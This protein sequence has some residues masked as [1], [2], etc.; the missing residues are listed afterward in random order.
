M[1]IAWIAVFVESGRGAQPVSIGIGNARAAT[2]NLDGGGDSCRY[3]L[4]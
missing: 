3:P 1:G 2:P 4:V